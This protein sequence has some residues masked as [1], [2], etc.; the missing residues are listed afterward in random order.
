MAGDDDGH[1][2]LAADPEEHLTAG[3]EPDVPSDDSLLLATVRNHAGQLR[4]LGATAPY[5]AAEHPGMALLASGLPH[6]FVNMAVHLA[7]PDTPDGAAGLDALDGFAAGHPGVPFLV[8]CLYGSGD[9]RA[10]GYAPVGHPPVMARA[11]G[12]EPPPSVTEARGVTVEE[13]TDAATLA[14]WERTAITGYPLPELADL[15][16]AAV[17]DPELLG[18]GW[19]FFLA[20]DDADGSP[21]GTS[22]AFVSDGLQVLQ[23]VAVLSSARGRGAGAAVSWAASTVEPDL[24]AVLVSSDLGRPVYERLGYLSLLRFPLWIATAPG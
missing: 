5:E 9:L 21:L 6:P 17:F 10:R 24:P 22:A 16:S 8:F 18:S 1:G 11:A 12:G 19:R 14:V 23:F 15:P 7:P 4:S 13:V 3:W 20:R 2:S